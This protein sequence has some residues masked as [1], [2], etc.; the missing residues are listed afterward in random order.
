VRPLRQCQWATRPPGS[1]RCAGSGAFARRFGCTLFPELSRAERRA[2][3]RRR[4]ICGRDWC[5]HNLS[6]LSGF[7]RITNPRRKC[8][9]PASA[10]APNSRQCRTG[11]GSR[12]GRFPCSSDSLRLAFPYQPAAGGW[13]QIP[14]YENMGG[15][16]FA[17][18]S[19]RL[20]V[21]HTLHTEPSTHKP[22]K[23]PPKLSFVIFI[24]GS[25][26]AQI[27]I[28]LSWPTAV[29]PSGRESLGL[30]GWRSG[31]L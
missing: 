7:I 26:P 1:A 25:L 28:L 16:S 20:P 19:E 21:P 30:T 22:A 13:P 12:R 5:G 9:H 6:G 17:S 4:S 15:F 31:L 8:F 24:L 2:G 27:S 23:T 3:R 11:Q 18:A 29:P 10:S 14:R